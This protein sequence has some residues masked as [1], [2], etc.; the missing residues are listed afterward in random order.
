MGEASEGDK[1]YTMDLDAST[2]FNNASV[3]EALNLKNFTGPWN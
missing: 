1:E 2:Y 3:R